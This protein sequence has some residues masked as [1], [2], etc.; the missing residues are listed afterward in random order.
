MQSKKLSVGRLTSLLALF[1]VAMFVTNNRAIAQESVL[2]NFNSSEYAAWGPTSGLIFDAAGNLYGTTLGGG[3]TCGT[4]CGTVFELSPQVSGGWNETVLHVFHNG[5][6]EGYY[7]QGGLVA[8][9]AGNLYGAAYYGGSGTNCSIFGGG[10]AFELLPTLGG[11]W[12][13]KVLHTFGSL[14]G[15]ADGGSPWAGLTFD[16][17]GNLYGTTTIGGAYGWGTVF[18][19]SPT[20]GGSWSE[21]VLHSFNGNDGQAPNSVLIFDSAGNLYGATQLGGPYYEGTVFELSPGAG[22]NWTHKVLH[23]FSTSSGGYLPEAGV[24]LDAA[25]NVYGTTS[26]GGA[27]TGCGIVCGTVFELSPTAQGWTKKTLHSFTNDGKDGYHPLGGLTFDAAGNLYGTTEYG[28]NSTLPNCNNGGCGTVF[29]L[30]RTAGGTW[31][32]RIVHNF[33]QY[34]N[35]GEYPEAGLIFDAGGHLYGTTSDGGPHL[36]GTVFEITH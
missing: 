18:E 25:G 28:G 24:V 6:Y 29:E 15:C 17:A 33:G 27:G 2:Y 21:T 14:P 30:T 4:G 8:D 31:A 11:G 26:L 32:E 10:T 5:D 7:P 3:T 36:G 34:K 9:A 13:E 23:G 12:T 22:G 16:V 35:D 19:L 1:T 20:A